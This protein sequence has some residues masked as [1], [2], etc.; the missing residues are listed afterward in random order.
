M[1]FKLLSGVA[2]L[3]LV[4]STA[5]ADGTLTI[6]VRGDPHNW[7]PIDTYLESWGVVASNIFDGL[8]RRDENLVLQPGLATSWEVL[9]DGM[10]M[11]F[12]LR[13]DVSFHN[14]EPFGA[15]AVKYTFDRLLGEIGKNGPQRSNYTSIESVEIID[16]QTVDFHM[17]S[18]DPV[19]LTKLS[20]YGAMIVPPK[21]IEKNGEED[22]DLNPVGTGPFKFVSYK[23]GDKMVLEANPDYFEGA[24]KMDEVVFRFIGEDSTRVA[25][26]QSGTVDIINRVPHSAISILKNAEGIDV[27][28]VTGSVIESLALK[29][30]EPAITADVRVRRAL[31]MAVDKQ[32]I[33]DAFL[34]GLGK[35]IAS[36]QGELSF[37]Y[38]NT[39]QGYPFDPV[40]AKALLDEAGVAP[41]T[42][43]TIDYRGDLSTF[44][45]VAQA[46]SGFYSE[47][48]L[49]VKLN[50]LESA[51]FLDEVVP[52]GQ[53]H[54]MFQF[55]WGGWT[56]D[57]DNTAYQA[58]HNGEKWNPYGTSE[59]M[60]ELLEKQRSVSDVKEREKLLQQIAR[61]AH[62][63]AY[64]VPLYSEYTPYALSDKVKG[65]IPAPDERLRLN[66]VSL[67]K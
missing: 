36:L 16:P 61:L 26:L 46:L 9:D 19:M 10:R 54:E 30:K 6:G 65:F 13:E 40:A 48:G 5:F 22:F 53:T 50:P 3:S 57:F 17:R 23:Q 25:E 4:A 42:E 27:V 20:G 38:D 58:Y 35:P 39:L 7:D 45:E 41:G 1:K 18:P 29:V 59:K 62:E 24:P 55:G 14:G 2:V 8:V 66:T 12:N 21:Y 67:E 31:N 44:H 43:L 49:N 51:V 47:I 52:K 37:G 15:D 60:N 28:A 11:R 63:E 56:F 34:A 33:V 64:H 32:A